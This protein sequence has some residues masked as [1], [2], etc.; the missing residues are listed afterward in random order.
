MSFIRFEFVNIMKDS[1]ENVKSLSQLIQ[2]QEKMLVLDREVFIF[3]LFSLFFIVLISFIIII[4]LSLQISRPI[5]K[6]RDSAEK[7]AKGDFTQPVDIQTNDETGQLGQSFNVMVAALAESKKENE[8]FMSMAA[9][10]LRHPLS[11]I[12]QA[13]SILETDIQGE[14]TDDLK[15]LILMI[16]KASKSM[17]ALVDD[18]LSINTFDALVF[19]ISPKKINIR[20]FAKAVFDFNEVQARKKEINFRLDLQ[21]EEEYCFID[22]EKI[23]QVLNNLLSNA[24]KFSSNKTSV[25]LTIKNN[26]SV[27]RFEVQDEAGGIP[28]KEQRFV[29]QRFGKISVK[30]TN[31]EASHGLGLS[32]CKNIVKAHGG[33][34]DFS[35]IYGKGSV[36]SFE[37]PINPPTSISS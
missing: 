37:L 27:L 18:L 30:P 5:I 6:L 31:G 11:V 10:D 32:T 24:F 21:L 23:A 33:Q 20:Q 2:F 8:E 28:E 25:T 14:E 19:Q 13:S 1:I 7:V 3:Y 4:F 17:L 12:I 36:F 16:Q 35:S 15:K 26:K 22:E 9:H 34:I 29:F